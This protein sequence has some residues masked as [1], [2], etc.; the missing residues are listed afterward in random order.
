MTT[1]M[2]SQFYRRV[3]RSSEYMCSLL[4]A[5]RVHIDYYYVYS[6]VSIVAL[7][8]LNGHA[9]RSWEY[10]KHGTTFMWLQ[11]SLPESVPG[12]RIMVY[13][14]NANVFEHVSTSRLRSFADTFL[15]RLRYMREGN[16]VSRYRDH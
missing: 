14:Y 11:D 6:P 3:V 13:G 10:H 15:E 7:H 2:G 16:T 1:L 5:H 9:I 8:G 4:P 12:A